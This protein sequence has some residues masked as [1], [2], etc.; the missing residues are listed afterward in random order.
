MPLPKSLFGLKASPMIY[1]IL[2]RNLRIPFQFGVYGPLPASQAKF[3]IPGRGGEGE[4]LR[5]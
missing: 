5:R 4:E 2:L 3:P 1:S